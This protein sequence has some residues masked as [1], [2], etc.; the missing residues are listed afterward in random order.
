VT[1]R[2]QL[3]VLGRLHELA[4][5]HLEGEPGGQAVDVVS[6]SSG[7]YHE[8]PK[9]AEFDSQIRQALEALGDLGITVAVSVG[10]DATSRPMYP[11]AFNPDFGPAALGTDKG[12]RHGR[13]PVIGVGA[14]NPDGSVALFTNGGPLVQHWEPGA[15]LVS[16]IAPFNCGA[17]P[18]YAAKDRADRR[19]TSRRALDPDDFRCGYAAWSGTSFAAPVLAG[20]LALRMIKDANSKEHVP[21]LADAKPGGPAAAGPGPAVDRAWAA[22]EAC[23]PFTRPPAP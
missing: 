14:L 13:A 22:I 12:P 9:D 18:P 8:T 16:S 1:S 21:G 11:A 3:L 15:C 4:R 5:R 10:N 20:R 7:Y 17:Q 23:T 19:G 6:L 2:D